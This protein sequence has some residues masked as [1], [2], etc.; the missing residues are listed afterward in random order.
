MSTCASTDSAFTAT[1]AMRLSGRLTGTLFRTPLRFASLALLA[2]AP[3]ARADWIL[4]RADAPVT[5]IH[6]SSV[7]QAQTGQRFSQD[8]IIESSGNGV[9]QIQDEGGNLVALGR[10]TRAMLTRDSHIALL[11]GWLKVMHECPDANCATPVVET[12]RTRFTPADR[13]TLVIAA[14]PEGYDGADAVFC[15]SGSAQILALGK[16]R[17]KPLDLRIDAHGSAFALH[18]KAGGT[19]SVSPSPEPAF[20]TAMPVAFRDA[21]RPLPLPSA[22]RALPTHGLRPVAYAEVADWLGGTLAVRTD[23][24]TRFTERFR[25][26]LPD[27]AFRRD[28]KQHIRALP[29]WRPLVFP[30]PRTTLKPLAAYSS[31][32]AR[33]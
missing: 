17:G 31:S 24:A 8:D 33:P 13:A 14:T 27:P 28:V 11:R 23:P 22:A 19:M 15:E 29:D 1:H 2:I 18:A 5:A 3:Y 26:R 6:A 21:L 12:E 10:D 32:S 25:A 7:Y 16:P 4:V 20:V 30:P 9:V